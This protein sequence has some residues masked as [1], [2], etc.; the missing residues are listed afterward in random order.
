MFKLYE[1]TEI[2]ENVWE[3]VNDEEVDLDEL[4]ET[5]KIIEDSIEA[6]AENTAKLIKSIEG[7]VETLR[8]EEKR[9]Y[10]KRRALENKIKGLKGYLEHELTIMGKDKVQGKLFTVAMQNNPPTVKFIDEDIIPEKYKERSEVVEIPKRA[11]LNDIKK[12]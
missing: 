10:S 3:M 8:E 11:I 6:K 9:L 12:A 2:Y 4:E 7:N 5:L 1:L